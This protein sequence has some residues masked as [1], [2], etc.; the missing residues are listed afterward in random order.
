M[1]RVRP[2]PTS[3][4]EPWPAITWRPARVRAGARRRTRWPHRR[5]WRCVRRRTAPWRWGAPP[6][7]MRFLEDALRVTADAAEE[8]AAICERIA[9]L[10][11]AAAEARRGPRVRHPRAGPVS[12]PG[13]MGRAPSGPRPPW[14]RAG[15]LAAIHRGHRAHRDD[16]RRAPRPRADAGPHRAPG[17]ARPRA[18]APGPRARGAGSGRSRPRGGR[19]GRPAGDH[20]RRADPAA[21]RWTTTAATGRVPRPCARRSRWRRRKGSMRRGSAATTTWRRPRE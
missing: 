21:R 2:A 14:R 8:E 17:P 3:L 15:E 13:V 1:V 9:R 7:A 5:A 18:H 4:R 16:L 11:A 6:Q 10:A 19:A 12:L 20:R